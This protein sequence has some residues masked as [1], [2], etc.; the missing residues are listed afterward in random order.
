MTAV[1]VAAATARLELVALLR[2]PGPVAVIAALAAF[3]LLTYHHLFDGGTSRIVAA[4]MYYV[5]TFAPVGIGVALADRFVRDRTLGVREVLDAL[6][7]GVAARV[8]GRFA[9]LVAGSGVPMLAVWLVQAGHIAVA[10]HDPGAIGL[11]VGAFA[12]GVL[13]GLVL[14]SALALIGPALLGI[15]LFRVVFVLYWFWGNL[16]PV[17]LA[18]SPSASW[19]TPIGGITLSA[20]FH[21][22]LGYQPVRL[23]DGAA[24]IT[25][26]TLAGVA[27]VAVL[28]YL[29]HRRRATA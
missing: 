23:T 10:R 25:V 19:F 20:I 24:S 21:A 9:G 22:D 17:Q 3:P 28:H 8:W 13:P 2:R 1:R 14:V 26:L 7:I 18:P 6:P 15:A 16:V 4:Q 29:E 12:V 5:N 11:A 27:L